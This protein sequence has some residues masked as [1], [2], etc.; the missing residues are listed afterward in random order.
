MKNFPIHKKVYIQLDKI[1]T[2]ITK[3]YGTT[4]IKNVFR[5]VRV[6]NVNTNI[7]HI[8]DKQEIH[9]VGPTETCVNT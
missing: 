8:V 3:M 4:S 7:A 6:R 2:F 9:Y 5:H 1:S